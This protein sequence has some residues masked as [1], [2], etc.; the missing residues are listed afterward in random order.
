ML[1]IVF[2]PEYEALARFSACVALAPYCASCRFW[3]SNWRVWPNAAGS[4]DGCVTD[5]PLATSVCSVDCCESSCWIS[6][7]MLFVTMLFVMRIGGKSRG[8][9]RGGH[10]GHQGVEQP[11]DHLE[12][13]GG[14]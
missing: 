13:F 4:S 8:L 3:L 11:G 14:G 5:R 10:V 7:S 6:A 1:I 12:D 2:R 9:A